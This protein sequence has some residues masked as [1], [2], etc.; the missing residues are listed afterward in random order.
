MEK[1]STSARWAEL[2]PPLEK[3][4]SGELTHLQLSGL[5]SA[6]APS[7]QL[8]LTSKGFL[9]AANRNLD[10]AMDS[11]H[12]DAVWVRDSVWGYLA[13]EADGETISAR[14]LLLGLVE[15]FSTPLQL[16]RFQRVIA[17]IPLN[18]AMDGL[19]IRFDAE[20]LDDVQING[21]AQHWNH[22]QHDAL[23]LFYQAVWDGLNG[24]I[25]SIEDIPRAAFPILT[26]FPRYF[27]AIEFWCQK[28]SGAWEEIERVNSSSIGLVTSSLETL[29]DF[30]NTE[31][32]ALAWSHLGGEDIATTSR[33]LRDLIEKG[34]ERLLAQLPFESP[35]HPK[36]SLLYREADAALL[37]LIYP[38]RLK[39]LSG[40]QKWGILQQV[41]RLVGE[42]GT[43]RYFGDTYQCGNYWV[44][45]DQNAQV[46]SETDDCSDPQAF[47]GRSQK[48][49]PDSEAQWF[50]DSWIAICTQKL[51]DADPSRKELPE[52]THQFL[53]RA[54]TQ[55]TD[56]DPEQCI[57][58]DGRKV[59]PLEFPESYNVLVSESRS[60]RPSPI[61]PLNWARASMRICLRTL[62]KTQTH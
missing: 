31:K 44:N 21:A 46:A 20:T 7:L 14:R 29:L 40:D 8:E 51:A 39:Q 11:T 59:G 6:L 34:Y 61:T 56:P 24:G 47:E 2:R 30:L 35:S 50:F 4:L 36:D 19:H 42:L 45:H 49:I 15:Y 26:G 57:G 54:L 41:R 55:L 53:S 27:S 25:L 43:K 60:F 33:L 9:K 52:L 58:A 3:V 32:G 16:A 10:G 17:G 28:D 37:A 12:Y 62:L 5:R 18:S 22:R 13:L 38:C 23:G 1:Q 48:F